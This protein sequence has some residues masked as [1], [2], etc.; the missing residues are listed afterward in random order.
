VE[1]IDS[2]LFALDIDVP[3]TLAKLTEDNRILTNKN[4]NLLL[5]SLALG[6]VIVGTAIY[7]HKKKKIEVYEQYREQ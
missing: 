7:Y 1:L 2:T 6:F 5:F 4:S 3:V